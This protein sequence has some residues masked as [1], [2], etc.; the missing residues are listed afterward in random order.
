MAIEKRPFGKTGHMSSAVLFGAAGIGRVDQGTADRVL[1]LLFRIRD[2]SHRRGA[3]LWRR[4]IADRPV[5][6][7]IPQGIFPGHKKI[8]RRDYVSARDQIRT[9]LDR[10]RTDHVD[11][12]QLHALFPSRRMG[13]GPVARR[14]ARRRARGARGRLGSSYRRHGA[15]LDHRRHAPARVGSVRVRRDPDALQLVHRQSRLLRTGLSRRRSPRRSGAASPYRPSSPWRAGR[16][17]PGWNVNRATWY[18]PLEGY[19]DIRAAVHWV[20]GR[21]GI[22]LNS[23]GDVD[24]LPLVL[25]AASEPIERPDDAT[26]ARLAERAGLT[27]IFGL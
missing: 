26:M 16:G 14:G 17:P 18:Q 9:S 1:D 19:E 24:L 6:G 22:F 11:L 3:T 2:Q 10:L 23:T 13:A 5:D 20:L 12:I 8:D 4:G 15:R 27:S 21:S 25:K 7:A